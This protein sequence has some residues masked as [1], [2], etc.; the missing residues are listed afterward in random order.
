MWGHARAPTSGSKSISFKHGFLAIYVESTF[1][2]A[3]IIHL[4]RGL[5]SNED[6]FVLEEDVEEACGAVE[7]P[8]HLSCINV[9]AGHEQGAGNQIRC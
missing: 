3:F 4:S 5:T 8:R 7:K 9:V 6:T 1:T 2:R